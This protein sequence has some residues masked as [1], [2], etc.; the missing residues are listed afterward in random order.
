MSVAHGS[1]RRKSPGEYWWACS[2]RAGQSPPM[3][4]AGL[5]ATTL[6]WK[7]MSWCSEH[8][9]DGAIPRGALYALLQLQGIH[10]VTTLEDGTTVCKPV[11]IEELAARLV[12]AGVWEKTEDGWQVVDYLAF[13]SSK[14]DVEAQRARQREKSAKGV[15]ARQRRAEERRREPVPDAKVRPLRPRKAAGS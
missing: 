6:W 3:L 10:E 7:G 8:L 13:Q 14:A 11:T 9:T 1:A 15:A 5:L 12:M 4:K 2:N